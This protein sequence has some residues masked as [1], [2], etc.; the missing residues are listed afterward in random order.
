VVDAMRM[1][2]SRSA[3]RQPLDAVD[4]RCPRLVPKIRIRTGSRA[5]VVDDAP[6][7]RTRLAARTPTIQIRDN[8]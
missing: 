8:F 5:R 3:D 2:P 6:Y 4:Y 7:R 1:Q